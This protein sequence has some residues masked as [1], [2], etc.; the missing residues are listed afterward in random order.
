MTGERLRREARGE[1]GGQAENVSEV[2]SKVTTTSWLGTTRGRNMRESL[3]MT[4]LTLSLTEMEYWQLGE[5]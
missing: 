2:R 5:R 3:S 4:S 1:E